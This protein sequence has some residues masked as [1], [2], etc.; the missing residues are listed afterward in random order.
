MPTAALA[1]AKG[2]AADATDSNIIPACRLTKW[3]VPVYAIRKTGL[4]EELT[5]IKSAYLPKK[6]GPSIC[7]G[8]W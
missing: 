6:L 3:L 7:S 2:I 8:S 4:S 1:T 5:L